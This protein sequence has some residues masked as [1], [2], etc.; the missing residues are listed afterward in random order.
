MKCNG[1]M[2]IGIYFQY[3]A[4][5]NKNKLKTV[6][7]NL[8]KRKKNWTDLILKQA[9]KIK[10]KMVFETVI[11]T[12]RNPP[13]EMRYFGIFLFQES[14]QI[15]ANKFFNYYS[16]IGWLIGGKQKWKMESSSKKLDAQHS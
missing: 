8:Q 14:S 16:S 13:S 12:I 10:Q 5:T 15:E 3:S 6:G 2:T 1:P 7:K 11:W 9:Q 4:D